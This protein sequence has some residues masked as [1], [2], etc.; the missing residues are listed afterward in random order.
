MSD[1]LKRGPLSRSIEN[2]RLGRDGAKIE[3]KIRVSILS[4]QSSGFGIP[5]GIPIRSTVYR[6]LLQRRE[7]H[8]ELVM[9]D[10]VDV[11]EDPSKH[12]SLCPSHTHPGVSNKRLACGISPR[13][14][15]KGRLRQ[16][17]Q[18][19]INVPRVE[20][21]EFGPSLRSPQQDMWRWKGI[22]AVSVTYFQLRTSH[23]D[24]YSLRNRDHAF[25]RNLI[26]RRI[27]SVPGCAFPSAR[28]APAPI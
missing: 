27:P 1:G 5:L 8:L 15:S 26:L 24:S 17:R 11:P 9:H 7:R 21:Q 23:R 4:S 10:E 2:L 13:C 18:T 16:P 14:G 12:V 3:I 19:D 28:P 25:K 20:R 22:E 6:R